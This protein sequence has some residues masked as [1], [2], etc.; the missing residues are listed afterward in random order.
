M[1]AWWIN[2]RPSRSVSVTD[3][4][5]SYADGLFETIAIR[6]GRLRFLDRH[7]DR[8]AGGCRRLSIPLPDRSTL[9]K[10]LA[11]AAQP[12]AHGVLKLIVS[13][14][15]GRRGYAPP[16]DPAPTL[17]FNVAAHPP[18][19]SGPIE[20]RWCE[21]MGAISPALAGLKTLGRLEQVL[22]RAE[23]SDPGVAEG[24]M[25]TPD[26]RL[27]GGTASNVFLVRDGTL[28]TPA[29]KDA[30]IAGVMRGVVLELADGA[31]IPW[32]ETDLERASAI[33]ASE[34]FMTNALT[35]LRPVRKL[36]ERVLEA[37]P[38]S[39]RLAEALCTIGVDECA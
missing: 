21:T 18:A 38:L 36:G 37:G 10:A 9:V 7:L 3:R 14:G 15:P 29:V 8:L 11:P 25:C 16:V 20:V 28:L 35:G 31:G 1:D 27:I 12:V 24:L 23:W 32:R 30:G 19:A 2:G 17:A 22:A 6:Q 34:I 4:G 39:R 5:F 33:Q 13:R 26:G